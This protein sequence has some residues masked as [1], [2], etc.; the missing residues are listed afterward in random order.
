MLSALIHAL[1]RSLR[2]FPA[3]SDIPP[4]LHEVIKIYKSTLLFNDALESLNPLF[5]VKDVFV[6]SQRFC[7][8]GSISFLN[9]LKHVIFIIQTQCVIW[10][11]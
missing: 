10:E 5:C 3:A 1:T 2:H 9:S 7:E 4:M 8:Q 6:G 11:V